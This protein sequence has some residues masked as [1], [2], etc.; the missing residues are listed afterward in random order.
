[1][2]PIGVGCLLGSVASF[3]I[4]TNSAALVGRS[5]PEEKIR[6]INE[7][8]EGDIMVRQIMDVKGIDMGNGIVRYKAEVDVDGRELA[9]Y[10]LSQRDMKSIMA[11]IKAIQSN[12]DLEVFMLRHG[13]HIVDCLGEQ[14]DRIEKELKS[15]HPELRYVDLEVL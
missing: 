4:Y 10:Y 3:M 15:Q 13:E 12:E 9:R 14:V 8:L 2:F 11:E 1:M 5:I 6:E 7:V